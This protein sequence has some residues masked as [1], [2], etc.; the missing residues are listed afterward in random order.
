MVKKIGRY[1]YLGVAVLFIAGIM[2]QV[3]LVGLSLL[4]RRPSWDDHIGLGHG[5]GILALL[6]VILVYVGQQS[7]G[8]KWLTWANFVVYFLLADVVIFMR[9]SA[10]LVAA[11]HPVLAITLFALTVTV[12]VQAWRAVREV[13]PA[14]ATPSPEMAREVSA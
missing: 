11:L 5:L 8:L 14:A 13:A 1:G 4:G 9:D 2:T 6:L 10:P 3:Y 12:A 7:R